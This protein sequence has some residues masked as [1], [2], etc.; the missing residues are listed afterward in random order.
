[1]AKASSR[2][3]GF[4]PAPFVTADHSGRL[5]VPFVAVIG[6]HR[7][8]S[9]CLA[10]VLPELGVHMGEEL[11]G[12]EP[13]GGFEAAEL[14]A[15]CESAYPFPSTEPTLPASEIVASLRRYET[16]VCAAAARHGRQ[17]AGGKY[18]H[19]FAMGTALR[20]VCGE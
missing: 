9:S 15:I 3:K 10:G 4:T 12:Y 11:T 13:T 19:L 18:P 16:K 1:M 17:L 2:Q 7:S 20:D 6:L 8:G 5:E 14:M